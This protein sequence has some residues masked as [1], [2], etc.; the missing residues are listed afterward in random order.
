[1]PVG[2]GALSPED[3][4]NLVDPFHISGYGRLLGQLRELGQEGWA[5]DVVG[6]EHGRAG[7]GGSGSELGR[8][9]HWIE[10]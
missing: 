2:V 7:L 10:S 3:G 4:A 8:S 9:A 5:A 6:P 1:M